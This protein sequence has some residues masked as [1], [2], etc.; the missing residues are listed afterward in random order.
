MTLLRATRDDWPRR[1]PSCDQITYCT[2][3]CTLAP[4]NQDAPFLTGP[5]AQFKLLLRM[6]RWA[7][8]PIDARDVA[9]TY[10]DR[11]WRWA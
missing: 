10:H 3:D 7:G 5:R 8:L 2:V 9:W 4:W 1:C 6:R 11:S